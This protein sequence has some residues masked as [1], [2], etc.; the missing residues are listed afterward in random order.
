M[1][2][3]FKFDTVKNKNKF[4][5]EINIYM[6]DNN[7]DFQ[8]FDYIN[9]VNIHYDYFTYSQIKFFITVYDFHL[10]VKYYGNDDFIIK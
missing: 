8:I 1:T 5:K 3:Q 4:I 10:D 9:Y 6:K 7:F 2:I